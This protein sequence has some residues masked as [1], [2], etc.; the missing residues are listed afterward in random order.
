MRRLLCVMLWAAGCATAPGPVDA[1]RVGEGT[2]DITPPAGTELAGFHKPA[3]RERRA[4]GVRQASFARVLLVSTPHGEF[5]LASLD[6]C[7]ISQEIARAVK[8]DVAREIGLRPERV[9]LCATHTHSMPTLRH[10]RQWGGLPADYAALVSQRIVEAA[11][12]ARQGLAPARFRLGK[13]RVAG[14]NFNRTTKTWKT[15][16]LFTKDS[17]AQ[18][19]WLDTTL[20]ALVFERDGGAPPLV[21]YQFSSHPVCY[22]DALS[23]PDW[24]GLVVDALRAADGIAPSFLQGHCGDVNPGGGT[25]WLG[26]PKKTAAAVADGLR[27]AIAAARPVALTTVRHAA[28]E[29]AAPL[30]LAKERERLAFYRADPAA[31]TKG[32]W[33]DA[34]FA[35]AWADVAARWDPAQTTYRTPMSA[36]RLG[37]VALLFH[38]GE[39]YSVYGLTIRRDAPFADTVVVGYTDDL[40]GYVPDPKAY[41]AGEYA[42]TVVPRIVDLPRFTPDVGRAFVECALGLLRSLAD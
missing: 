7:G 6:V 21:W 27:R 2:A 13:A 39:L 42:A 14:G 25:P 12:A 28:G 41:E 35:Q 3:G 18:D 8:A 23:G 32:E 22:T 19:R 26:D 24:P 9:H 10:L 37:D 15:D 33:V 38:S 20:H 29:F 11:R 34:G 36:L 40:I 5:A 31:C 17:T 30:D 16:E 1:L 4:E